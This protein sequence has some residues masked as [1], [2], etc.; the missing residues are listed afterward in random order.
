MTKC[1][2]ETN[3]RALETMETKTITRENNEEQDNRPRDN[4]VPIY[5]RQWAVRQ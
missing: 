2:S 1:P 5:G 3:N 4:R